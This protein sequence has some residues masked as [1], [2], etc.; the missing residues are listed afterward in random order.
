MN[1]QSVEWLLALK[2]F[3]AMSKFENMIIGSIGAL[4]LFHKRNKLINILTNNLL[5]RVFEA[6]FPVKC[7]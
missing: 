3:L 2:K 1:N 6:Y 4:A 5:V 7:G